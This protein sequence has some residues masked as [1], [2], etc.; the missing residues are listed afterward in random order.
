MAGGRKERRQRE[1][2][3]HREIEQDRRGGGG[4]EALQ[5][6]EDAAIERHQRDQQQIG[7]C[8]AGEIDRER[9]AAGIVRKAR[10]QHI[11]HRRRE[12]QRDRQQHDLA[13]QQQREDA[14]GEQPGA[15]R[16][17][18]LADAGIGRHEGG[19][20]GALGENRAEMIGQPQRD[21]KGVG[22]GAGARA[23]PPG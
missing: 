22:H 18:L 4:G 20:E 16:A 3:H 2:H 9:V 15:L 12:H 5:R 8:D 11:D 19:V 7:K 13:R 6:I 1:R 21:K 17:A 14:V 23:P 10:R